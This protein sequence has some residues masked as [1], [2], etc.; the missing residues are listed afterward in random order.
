MGKQQTKQ[1]NGRKKKKE[2]RFLVWMTSHDAGSAKISG[3]RARWS[4]KTG[5]R[6]ETIENNAF[7]VIWGLQ[8]NKEMDGR[9]KP[10]ERKKTNKTK[11]QNFKRPQTLF[12]KD[13]RATR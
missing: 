12:L 8:S 7:A 10:N 3:G 2:T 9:Q 6:K 13:L 4:H 1:K 5:E 11:W